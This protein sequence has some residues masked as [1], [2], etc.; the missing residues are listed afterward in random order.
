MER[1][2]VRFRLLRLA[3]WVSSEP[4]PTSAP[5]SGARAALTSCAARKSRALAGGAPSGVQPEGVEFESDRSGDR[6][7]RP[8]PRERVE[9]P[10]GHP[11]GGPRRRRLPSREVSL[12]RGMRASGRAFGRLASAIRRGVPRPLSGVWLPP[13]GLVGSVEAAEAKHLETLARTRVATWSALRRGLRPS[14]VGPLGAGPGLRGVSLGGPDRSARSTAPASPDLG[15]R[16]R[17]RSG[18]TTSGDASR[19]STPSGV[20]T[21]PR[22]VSWVSWSRLRAGSRWRGSAQAGFDGHS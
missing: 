6:R 14:G 3:G 21:F 13:G 12:P 4:C 5:L 8:D 2:S 7:A 18:S 11:S 15:V 17:G 9:S 20:S 10:R 19:L 16:A 1:T 22:G